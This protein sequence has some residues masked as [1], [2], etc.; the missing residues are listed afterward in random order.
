M[1][2][3]F[4]IHNLE[5]KEVKVTGDSF[6]IHNL[7]YINF[8]LLFESEI[9]LFLNE[10]WGRVHSMKNWQGIPTTCLTLDGEVMAP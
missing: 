4:I 9:V 8:R 1:G 2:D 5:S 10:V 7:E 3:S 6:I